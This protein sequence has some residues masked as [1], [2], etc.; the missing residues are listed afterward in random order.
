MKWRL[1]SHI[2]N[3]VAALPSG[4]SYALYYFIQRH[5]GGLRVVNPMLRLRAGLQVVDRLH[6]MQRPVESRAFL[7]VGTGDNINL[8]L[9]L[10][11]SGA[12]G[13]TTVDLNPY[14]R[15]H[16]VFRDLAFIQRHRSEV[17]ELFA[18]HTGTPL[19]AQRLEALMRWNGDDLGEFL[20]HTRIRYL[21][22]ADAAS[23]PLSSGS[24]DYH[25]SYTVLEHIPPDILV[26][27]LR[28]GSR[29]LTSDGLF[30]HCVDFS[31]HFAHS[32]PTISS[33]N[34]L[35]FSEE[36]W[37][38]LSG[39]RYMYQNR[40]RLD[41]FM[42][43]MGRAALEPLSID[44]IVDP[45]AKQLLERGGLS[46]APRFRAKPPDTNATIDAWVIAQPSESAKG[47]PLA[48]SKP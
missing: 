20:D 40:L 24:I 9:A 27:I 39:N 44:A 31:D 12:S 23:L 1:K 45:E 11:L 19:F 8:P 15:S 37:N 34:F 33:I 36:E 38:R 42:H 28:E 48:S 25:V 29:V 46:L 2:Q 17:L 30:V 3:A 22:P 26:A 41:E 5:W 4:P 14:L 7:E 21:A 43:L 16:L 10:W 47:Q 32:D 13:T 35:Q 6:R 18:S